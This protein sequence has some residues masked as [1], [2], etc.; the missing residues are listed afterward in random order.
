MATE[1][2][3]LFREIH[4]LRKHIR[5]VKSEIENLPRL[6]KAHQAKVA[7]QEAALKDAQEQVKKAKSDNH[8]REVSL[9]STEQQLQ[10]YE[11][12]LNDMKSP[13]EVEAKEHEIA[14]AKAHIGELEDQILN[15]MGEVEVKVAKVPAFEEQVKKAKAEY[16]TFEAE[17]NEREERLKGEA[18]LAAEQLA[19]AEPQ[20]PATTRPIY[21]R[22]TKA[23]GADALAQVGRRDRICSNCLTAVTVQ[24]INELTNGNLT[25]CN[26]CGRV[27]YLEA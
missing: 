17:F 15:G 23:H 25:C 12:Q 1:I 6:K 19:L 22:L 20:I 8:G 5:E 2:N 18:K 13:K 21:D 10:K 27:V 24:A 26:S 4:R 9:K 7:K 14:T 11:R 16:A 3:A